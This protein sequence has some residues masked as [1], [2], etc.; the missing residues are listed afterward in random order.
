MARFTLDT[1]TAFVSTQ[2]SSYDTQL[3]VTKQLLGSCVD[4]LSAGLPYPV[5]HTDQLTTT[6]PRHHSDVFAHAFASAQHKI[7]ARTWKGPSWPLLEIFGDVTKADNEV[8]DGFIGPILNEAL[9]KK[10]KNDEAGIKLNP[11][12][13]EDTML[14]S[15]LSQTDNHKL[16]RDEILNIL[17][18]GGYLL[19]KQINLS[20]DPYSILGRDTVRG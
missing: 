16:L 10:R 19:G 11:E 15:L 8:I 9:A 20:I 7:G 18:A 12:D 5:S 3:N 1:A 2:S 17:I 4:S 13:M 6:I 14:N